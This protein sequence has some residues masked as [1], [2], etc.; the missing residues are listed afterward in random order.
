MANASMHDGRQ[1]H[2][3]RA[4]SLLLTPDFLLMGLRMLDTGLCLTGLCFGRQA[5][6]AVHVRLLLQLVLPFR[7]ECGLHEVL[8]LQESFQTCSHGQTFRL[9]A[10][11]EPEKWNRAFLYVAFCYSAAVSTFARPCIVHHH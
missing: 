1:R 11:I 9:S 10:F 4:S 2:H 8:R 6:S 5:S 3:L 7:S